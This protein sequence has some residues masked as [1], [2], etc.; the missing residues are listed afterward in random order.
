ME[1]SKNIFI[2]DL[3]ICDLIICPNQ[4]CIR[5]NLLERLR[6]SFRFCTI[7]DPNFEFVLRFLLYKY[8]NNYCMDM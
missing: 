3:I 4:L 8:M 6:F 2:F 5:I 1:M 7:V